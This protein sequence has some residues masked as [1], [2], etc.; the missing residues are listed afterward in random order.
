MG[1]ERGWGSVFLCIIHTEY[2]FKI[3][4]MIF[5][6]IFYQCSTQKR[7][8]SVLR[9]CLVYLRPVVDVLSI[10]PGVRWATFLSSPSSP[11]P[12]LDLKKITMQSLLFHLCHY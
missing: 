4:A 1:G 7:L 11:L 6:L 2:Y 3:L 10:S 12:L 9:G 5:V 8:L